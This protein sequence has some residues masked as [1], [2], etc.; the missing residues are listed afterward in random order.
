MIK[1][2]IFSSLLISRILNVQLFSEYFNLAGFYRMTIPI[3]F[4]LLPIYLKRAAFSTEYHV[5]N[6]EYFRLVD[7]QTALYQ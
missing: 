5:V 6:H 4:I 1:L 2:M 7:Q 3:M